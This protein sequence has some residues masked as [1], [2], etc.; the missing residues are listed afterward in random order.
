M[1]GMIRILRICPFK[2]IIA[3]PSILL[4][5]LDEPVK[6]ARPSSFVQGIIYPANLKYQKH[7]LLSSSFASSW[8]APRAQSDSTQSRLLKDPGIIEAHM[9]EHCLVWLF[10]S[11]K[12]LKDKVVLPLLDQFKREKKKRRAANWPTKFEWPSLE[13]VGGQTEER[14]KCLIWKAH[15]P[16]S[17][18]L[19]FLSHSLLHS[20]FPNCVHPSIQCT[21]NYKHGTVGTQ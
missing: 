21:S 1:I 5:V 18:V 10:C 16:I 9:W 14:S 12:Q 19:S 4:P 13:S 3:L 2:L 8:H 11:W 17:W 6:F 20:F 15:L 7:H